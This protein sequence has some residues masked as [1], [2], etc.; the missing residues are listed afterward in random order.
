[1]RSLGDIAEAIGQSLGN[2]LRRVVGRKTRAKGYSKH[3]KMFCKGNSRRALKRKRL[4]DNPSVVHDGWGL[5]H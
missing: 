4:R 2:V 1:M 5:R 3:M